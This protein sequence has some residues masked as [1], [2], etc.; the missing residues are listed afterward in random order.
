MSGLPE[1]DFDL[2]E[3]YSGLIPIDYSNTSEA[4]FFIFQPT[5]GAPVDEVTIWLNGGPGCSSL[6]GFFQEN[7]RFIWP[8]GTYKPYEN[9]YAW[10]NLTN[11]LW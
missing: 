7:G 10:T 4:L 6:E 8:P 9:P 11:M 2:G 3:F 5:T 1:V